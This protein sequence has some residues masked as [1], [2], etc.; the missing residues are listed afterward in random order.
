MSGRREDS[1]L[2]A[3]G[4]SLT[5]HG[6]W[7][8]L[9]AGAA[10]WQIE[11]IAHAG[12]TS[13]EIALRLGVIRM[14]FSAAGAV[15]EDRIPLK[16]VGP[17]GDFRHHIDSGMEDIAV[18]G[19][20]A[21]RPGLLTHRVGGAALEGW[22]FASDGAAPTADA[23][24]D[25]RAE[26]PVFSA[27]AAFV[28]WCGRNNPGPVAAR[29]VAAIVAELHARHSAA[30]CLVLGVHAASFEPIGSEGVALVD[31]LNAT[32][33][34]T[35]GDHFVDLGAVFREAAP[36]SDGTTA[37]QLRSDDVHL[38][39]AGDAVVARAVARRLSELGWWPTGMTLPS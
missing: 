12:Q 36:T 15:Q 8:E 27:P 2:I 4:D 10:G 3:I 7:P 30:R 1:A 16:P 33:A 9:L 17:S 13:T 25:F 38:N 23:V 39:A 21:G 24:L 29:D 35:F 11:R 20:L 31:G 18:P 22:E 32:L 6:T 26:V 37:A 19:T 14:T 28:I 34:Q 5:E